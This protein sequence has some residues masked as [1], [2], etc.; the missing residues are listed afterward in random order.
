MFKRSKGPAIQVGSARP[1]LYKNSRKERR[2]QRRQGLFGRL[3]RGLLGLMLLVACVGLAGGVTWL[4]ANHNF[5]AEGPLTERTVV[6]I[7]RGSGTTEISQKLADVGVISNARLF[8]GGILYNRT[9]NALKAGEYAFPPGISMAGVMDMLVNGQA[10]TYKVSIPEGLTS[11]QAITRLQSAELLEGEL[12]VVPPEGSLL[13]DTY[14]FERGA[15][16]ADILKQ[17]QTAQR[18]LITELWPNRASDLPVKTAREAIILASIVEKETALAEERPQVAAVF[19]NRLRKGMRLQSD[20]TIIYGIVGGKGKLGRALTRKDIDTPTR[21][22]TY[23]IPGLPPT[24]ISN[25]GKDAIA[26][27]LNPPQTEN[28]FF[29]ADG[30]GGHAFAKTLDEHNANVKKWREYEEAQKIARAEKKKKAEQEAI[31]K[32]LAGEG[33]LPKPEENDLRAIAAF[34]EKVEEAGYVTKDVVEKLV[35]NTLPLPR[36][37]P[38]QTQ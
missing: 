18:S 17:M 36:Q 25:P 32:A 8:Q 26:A 24:P 16:R 38:V 22:N 20:P 15:S 13:P 10:I 35:S 21:Y 37:K 6:N 30:T 23:T 5:E 1:D 12:A 2:R 28:L 3:V 14:V 31:A 29:V 11:Q 34:A 4:V 27:V 7:E 9:Q 19:I 33:N